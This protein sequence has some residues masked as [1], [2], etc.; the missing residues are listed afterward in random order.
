MKIL[1]ISPIHPESIDSL[2]RDHD[3]RC[4]FKPD[5]G[6]LPGLIAD[7]EVLI[8]RSGVTV[9]EELLQSASDL[10][11]LVR[12]GS[13][14]DNID[15][16]G[17]RSHDLRLVRVPG[18]GA[19][20]VAELTFGLL[21]SLARNVTLADRLI[22]QGHW[23]KH[24]LG[25]PLVSGKTL[26][27]LGAGNIGC[28]VGDLGVAW[29]M[30]VIGCVEHGSDTRATE[31]AARGI[32][33]TDC[34][35]V[36]SEADFLTLHVPLTEATYHMMGA[37]SLARMKSG[38]FLINAARGGVVDEDALY[39]ELTQPGRLRGA[40]LDV[41][42]REGEGIVPLLAELPNVVLTPHI[43]AMATDSQR[44]IGRRV[45]RIIESFID[46][47]IEEEAKDGELVA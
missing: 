33:L 41:H 10:R 35:T 43:G 40:A 29:G 1:L 20:A 18:P 39:A 8:F 26:G 9:S 27:I 44:A 15:L 46:G 32:T 14:L 38:S 7:R 28:H 45:I 31:L 23:P 6:E 34:S 22:R 25:G 3:V 42:K 30:R 19:Q 4:A 24:D 11:L 47:R 17:V 13:G 5:A 21:L 37:S 36:V 12:A 2:S 16:A